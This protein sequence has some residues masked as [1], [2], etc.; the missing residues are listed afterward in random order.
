MTPLLCFVAS[1]N[2]FGEA[3]IAAE[4][5]E[6]QKIFAKKKGIDRTEKDARIVIGKWFDGD[7]L[8]PV[9]E[10]VFVTPGLLSRWLGYQQAS[11]TSP[12]DV[13]SSWLK[14]SSQF[15]N[16]VVTLIR[17][18]RLCTVDMVDGDV[19]SSAKPAALDSIKI[20]I[21]QIG[22]PWEAITYRTVQDIL[23]RRPEDVLKET[24]DQILAKFTAWPSQATENDLN[25]E[26]RWGLNRRVSL[27]A[28][29]PTLG[30]GSKCEMKI[31]DK[32]RTR[33]IPFNYPKS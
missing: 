10:A 7:R 18:A 20:Q 32:E 23:E 31:V 33:V 5:T 30:A 19:D 28:D 26:I 17:L 6:G 8:Q 3:P 29:T 15:S 13:K 25:P 12:E 14:C 9:E 2:A 21:R 4:F 22:K 11:G 24:W 1:F 16:K 27:I